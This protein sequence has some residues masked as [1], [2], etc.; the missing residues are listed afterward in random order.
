MTSRPELPPGITSDQ[1][2]SYTI[3]KGIL[4]R[5][6][7]YVGVGLLAGGLAS[8]VLAKGGGGSRKIITAFGTGIGLGSAWTRTSMELEDILKDYQ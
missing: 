6:G 1:A 4:E 2:V 5:G 7:L 3:K 8:I